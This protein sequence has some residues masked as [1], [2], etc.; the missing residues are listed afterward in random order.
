[1]AGT[2]AA[3]GPRASRGRGPGTHLRPG[4]LVRGGRDR[5]AD[6]QPAISLDAPPNGGVVELFTIVYN[7]CESGRSSR[8]LGMTVPRPLGADRLT[9]IMA[10]GNVHTHALDFTI[11]C[12]CTCELF[13]RE[14]CDPGIAGYVASPRFVRTRLSAA[15]DRIHAD[16]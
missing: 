10:Q 4:Q 13:R 14:L 3:G 12:C 5:V 6:V 16:R 2:A 9:R 7:P 1:M 11:G 15:T 8:E